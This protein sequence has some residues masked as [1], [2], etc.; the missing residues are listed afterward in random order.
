[1]GTPKN[2]KLNLP[3]IKLKSVNDSNQV[4]KKIVVKKKTTSEVSEPSDELTKFLI[5]NL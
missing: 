1:M 4:K 3:L 5:T 2:I